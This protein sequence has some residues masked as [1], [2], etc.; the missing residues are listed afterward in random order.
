MFTWQ[1]VY[2]DTA[3]NVTHILVFPEATIQLTIDDDAA[4]HFPYRTAQWT[5]NVLHM[6]NCRFNLTSLKFSTVVV[7]IG[8]YWS[9]LLMMAITMFE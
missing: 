1:C 2:N 5:E 9:R 8:S 6:C 4:V 7:D 3:Y